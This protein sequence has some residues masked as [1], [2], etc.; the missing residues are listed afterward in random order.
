[1]DYGSRS[2]DF[3]LQSICDR[4]VKEGE[5]NT[6]YVLVCHQGCVHSVLTATL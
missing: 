4:A 5:K 6:Y 1:M 3:H 2:E